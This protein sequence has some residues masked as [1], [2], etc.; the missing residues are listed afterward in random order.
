M[1]QNI[2][3]LGFDDGIKPNEFPDRFVSAYDLEREEL[4]FKEEQGI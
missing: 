3:D 4:Q 1:N 2:T